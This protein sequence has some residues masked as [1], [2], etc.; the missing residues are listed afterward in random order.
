MHNR[1]GVFGPVT[2]LS[3]AIGQ[4]LPSWLRKL[5]ENELVVVAV[6][7][8]NENWRESTL[9]LVDAESGMKFIALLADAG[10]S[11]R[12]YMLMVVSEEELANGRFEFFDEHNPY[13]FVMDQA[14]R[15]YPKWLASGLG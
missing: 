14:V 12:R 1:K 3:H 7:G 9:Y 4:V 13:E 10:A 2:D 11:P 8:E 5:E 6:C 15:A